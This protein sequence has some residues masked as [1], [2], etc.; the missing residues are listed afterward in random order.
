LLPLAETVRIMQVLDEVRG[1]LG[2]RF[3]DE[4]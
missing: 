2:V 3:P 4:D 1:Q